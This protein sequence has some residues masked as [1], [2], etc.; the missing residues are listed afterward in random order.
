MIAGGIISLVLILAGKLLHDYF[1]R[2][3]KKKPVNH[4]MEGSI[5]GILLTGS[6]IFF[7]CG[8]HDS[9]IVFKLV[10]SWC[11]VCLIFWTLFDG[12]FNIIRR[13]RWNFTGSVDKDDA[14]LDKLQRKYP[15]LWVA[16][17]FLSIG[18]IIIYTLL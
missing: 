9:P 12:L 5:V 18:L 14:K 13:E 4:D 8:L 11:M 17:I 1:L 7:A 16:K 15:W 10:Y 2:W 6:S 3:K